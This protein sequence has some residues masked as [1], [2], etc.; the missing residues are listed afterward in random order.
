MDAMPRD[1]SAGAIAASGLL[2]LARFV[3][4]E[5][6]GLYYQ[7]AL[8]IL[9]GLN[10]TCA[11]WNDTDEEGILRHGTSNYP[12]GVGVDRPLI[13]GDYFFI[14]ALAKLKGR[15]GLFYRV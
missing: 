11:T 15:S 4:Q 5:E 2:E 12:Q 9:Q 3:S 1:S 8:H 13:Y 6:R 14:E 10:D 7:G